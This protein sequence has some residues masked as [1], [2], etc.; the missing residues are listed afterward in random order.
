[1]TFRKN[2]RII[3]L[4]IVKEITQAYG[5]YVEFKLSEKV[6]RNSLNYESAEKLSQIMSFI[7]NKEVL[8][9]ELLHTTEEITN[10]L[11]EK[12]NKLKESYH[13]LKNSL[14]LSKK[15]VNKIFTQLS[16]TIL[17]MPAYY[18]IIPRNCDVLTYYILGFIDKEELENNFIV[19]CITGKHK[20]MKPR[21]FYRI[22]SDV[23]KIYHKNNK[24]KK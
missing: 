20:P 23:L 8:P 22:Y 24:K 13:N 14:G 9:E 2:K 3:N 21:V 17:K 7:V 10:D 15:S 18:V 11:I 6:I 12:Y 1:M 16:K 19:L 5:N 4:F